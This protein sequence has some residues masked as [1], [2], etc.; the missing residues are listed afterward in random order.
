MIIPFQA[1]LLGKGLHVQPGGGAGRSKSAEAPAGIAK[2]ASEALHVSGVDVRLASIVKS[3][4]QIDQ[5]VRIASAVEGAHA[6][7]NE[8]TITE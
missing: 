4:T 7:H 2:P 1:H 5:A 6:I 3:R 8:L